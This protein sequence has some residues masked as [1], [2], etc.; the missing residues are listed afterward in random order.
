MTLSV[1]DNL[2]AEVD[3]RFDGGVAALGSGSR[4]RGKAPRATD[5]R[6]GQFGA[7]ILTGGQMQQLLRAALIFSVATLSASTQQQVL[8]GKWEIGFRSPSSEQPKTFSTVELEFKLDDGK[9][10]G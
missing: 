2:E 1:F 10:S 4:G 9:L 8:T 3:Y 6:V 7:R 5:T